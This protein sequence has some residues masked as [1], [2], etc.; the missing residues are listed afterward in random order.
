MD[1]VTARKQPGKFIISAAILLIM[2]IIIIVLWR[3]GKSFE[4]T[5]NAQLDCNIV[6]V[7]SLV[8]AYARSIRFADNE[9]VKKDQILMIF[10]SAELR[11]R[12]DQAE[13]ALAI[14]NI[15]LFSARNKAKA[16]NENASAGDLTAESYEQSIISAKANLEKAQSIYNRTSDLLKLKGVTQEQF[17][18]AGAN[19]SVAKADFA[20]AVNLHKSTSNTSM[21]LKLLAKS[22]ENQIALAEE[23]IEQCK[24]D[25]LLAKRQLDYAI[26]RAP[27][28]G[29]VS[30]RSVEVNQFVSAGQN[31]CVVVENENMWVTANVKETQLRNLRAGQSV[32][33]KIDAYPDLALKGKIESFS[34]ATGAKYSLL[35]PDNSTGNFIKIIQRIPVKISISE[36]P[37]ERVQFLFPGMSVY[38]KISLE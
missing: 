31:L 37:K 36:I 24:A 10:D 13:A 23:Q 28:D 12:Y 25:L 32:K 35:P 1:H 5:D 26:V 18:A 27:C 22:D 17:E 7:R 14:A 34:G 30:K 21:G 4:T 38:V 16:S 33:I 20:K 29:I 9:H 8:A 11:A 6:P 3:K 15:K 19:L 2:A